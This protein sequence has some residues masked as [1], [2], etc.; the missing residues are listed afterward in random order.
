MAKKLESFQQHLF[1]SIW[2]QVPNLGP[3]WSAWLPL[4]HRHCLLLRMC[5]RMMFVYPAFS[6]SNVS[7]VNLLWRP[8][9][10]LSGR[11]ERRHPTALIQ[12][13]S[14]AGGM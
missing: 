1:S 2:D 13:G 9:Q 4:F 6:S 11:W 3:F 7:S 12:S 14:F 8:G 10:K 5:K